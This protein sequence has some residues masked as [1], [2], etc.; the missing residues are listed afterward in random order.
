MNRSK[1][2]VM[3]TMKKSSCVLREKPAHDLLLASVASMIITPTKWMPSPTYRNAFH[4]KSG[5]SSSMPS[6]TSAVLP[7]I[8]CN[9]ELFD[10]NYPQVIESIQVMLTT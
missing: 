8:L 10:D 9:I 1:Y 3:K 2:R 4:E 7:V 5:V 6:T